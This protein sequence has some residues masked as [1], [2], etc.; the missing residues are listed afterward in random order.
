MKDQLVNSLLMMKSN[1]IVTK[2]FHLAAGVVFWILKQRSV[3]SATAIS[4]IPRREA[5]SA[6]GTTKCW[7]T[8]AFK[9]FGR[10]TL[11]S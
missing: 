9:S 10:N 8:R 2:I 6:G 3:N 1:F 11:E 4:R 5:R 7:R